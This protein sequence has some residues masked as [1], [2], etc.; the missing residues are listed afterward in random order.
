M[1]VLQSFAEST[2]SECLAV[3]LEICAL[4]SLPDD[5]DAQPSWRNIVL[6]L[7]NVLEVL[8]TQEKSSKYG[9]GVWERDPVWNIGQIN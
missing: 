7:E 6:E 4:K 2:E 5:C 1:T 8:M 3:G 9:A